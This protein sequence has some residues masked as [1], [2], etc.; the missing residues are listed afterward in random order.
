MPWRT[1]DYAYHLVMRE[2]DNNNPRVLAFS[3]WLQDEVRDYCESVR[4]VTG[5]YLPQR[6]ETV[7]Q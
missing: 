4:T 1:T 7:G 6:V 3:E 2:S 5:F